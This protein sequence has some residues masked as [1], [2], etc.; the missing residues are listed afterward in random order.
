LA[1]A[2]GELEDAVQTI[3]MPIWRK[4]QLF[5]KVGIFPNQHSRREGLVTE[6]CFVFQEGTSSLVPSFPELESRDIL[7]SGEFLFSG[8]L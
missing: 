3:A 2:H 7:R 5:K 8:D 4:S 6:F 1:C